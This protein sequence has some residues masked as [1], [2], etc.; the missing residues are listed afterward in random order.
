MSKQTRRLP[1]EALAKCPTGIRGLDEITGGGLPR[2]RPTLVCGGPG[3][4]KTLLGIEFLVRGATRV[5]RARRLRELRGDA[6]RSWRRTSFSLGFDLGRL[7]RSKRFAV[8]HIVHRPQRVSKTGE[9]DLEGLFIRLGCAIDSVGAKRVVLDTIEA[10]FGGL[11]NQAHP[12]RRAR[13][14]VSLAEG[15]GRHGGHHRRARRGHADAPWPRGVRLGLR[16]PARPPRRR[17]DRRPGGC[18]SS[19][20]AA[21]PTARTSIRS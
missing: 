21:R 15:Q 10:L 19:S 12:A 7:V 8:E 6:P 9:Y 14:P 1:A 18:A 17:S 20:I 4:G 3:A 2:G 5:R 16:D 11:T 13:A